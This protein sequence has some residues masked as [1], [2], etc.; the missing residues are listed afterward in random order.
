MTYSTNFQILHTKIF[1][2]KIWETEQDVLCFNFCRNHGFCVTSFNFYLKSEIHDILRL[3]SFFSMPWFSSIANLWLISSQKNLAIF[4]SFKNKKILTI[5]TFFFSLLLIFFLYKNHFWNDKN[6]L[7]VIKKFNKK[8]NSH[9]FAFN[10]LS[11]F[12]NIFIW[13]IVTFSCYCCCWGGL[14][15]NL[16]TLISI[17]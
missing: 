4:F 16:V 9:I 2:W 3:F 10:N 13:K 5:I 1:V 6:S 15:K 17:T 14:M 8:R 12:E 7:Q 11:H